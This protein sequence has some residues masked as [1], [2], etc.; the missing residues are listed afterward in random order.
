MTALLLALAGFSLILVA[1]FAA[2]PRRRED[3][4][5]PMSLAIL[6]LVLCSGWVQLSP[7]RAPEQAGATSRVAQLARAAR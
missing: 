5:G 3:F 7:D 1:L 2:M 6:A 4:A